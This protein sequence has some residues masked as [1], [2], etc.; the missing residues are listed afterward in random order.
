MGNKIKDIELQ[1]EVSLTLCI[2]VLDNYTEDIRQTADLS[3]N[4]YKR[5]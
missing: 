5:L 3:T 1:R 2:R 4:A